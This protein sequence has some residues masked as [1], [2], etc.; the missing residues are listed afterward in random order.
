MTELSPYQKFASNMLDKDSVYIPKILRNMINDQQAELLVSLPGTAAELSGKTGRSETDINADLKDMFRKGLSF[1]K[2]KQGQPTY[3]RPPMHLAQFHDATI[4]WP[5]AT[6]EFYDL[7]EAYMEKEWPKLAP[8]LANFL[9][10]PFTRVIPVG[11]SLDAGKAKILTYENM[12]DIIN[13]ADKIAVTKCTCRLTMHKCDA[14]I[15]VCIQINRG[16]DYTIERGTGREITKEEAH[17]IIR[18]S[19]EAGLVHVTMN[20]TGI[21]HFICNCCGC[22]CQSFTLLISDG[23]SLC[24][25]SRYRPEVDVDTC[26]A[27][28]ACEERCFFNAIA[29]GDAESAVVNLDKCMG[30]GQCAIGCPEDAIAMVEIREPAFIPD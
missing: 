22:C 2:E 28:G 1:K 11:K 21:G 10:R 27:C 7:W 6:Q 3:W 14:P 5:E 19:A 12:I 13:D 23:V 26:T 30:C 16:A 18:E 4:V 15:E 17:N 25:P 29:I 24:D 9:P 8:Q 20:K